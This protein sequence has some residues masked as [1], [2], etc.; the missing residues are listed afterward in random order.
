MSVF[1][2]LLKHC[3]FL[4]LFSPSFL[5]DDYNMYGGED[6]YYYGLEAAVASV[7][8]TTTGSKFGEALL[9]LFAFEPLMFGSHSGGSNSAYSPRNDNSSEGINFGDLTTRERE[10]CSTEGPAYC[11]HDWCE[12][13]PQIQKWQ[14]F[15]GIILT[16]TCYPFCLA[17]VQALFSKVLGPRPQVSSL[18]TI[19]R[20]R[21]CPANLNRVVQ[22]QNVT[23]KEFSFHL[24]L[25]KKTSCAGAIILTICTHDYVWAKK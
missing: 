20:L 10:D 21:H 2:C 18:S 6:S 22:I 15:L 1:L 8:T 9:S 5:D 25:L 16:F 23:R 17:I 11:G 24:S 3:L 14:F 13:T 4:S 7:A 19:P 12:D